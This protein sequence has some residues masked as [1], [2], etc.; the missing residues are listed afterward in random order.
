MN[1]I[2]THCHLYLPEFDNDLQEVFKRAEMEGVTKFYLP[3]IDSSLAG[4]ML[5]IE[6]SYPEQCFVMTGL[7]PC[8]VNES[9]ETELKIVENSL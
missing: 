4:K 7:H 8:S 6:H 2:D 9:F 1:L 5:A 3:A